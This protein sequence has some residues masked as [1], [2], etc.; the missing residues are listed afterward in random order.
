MGID[1]HGLH[2]LQRVSRLRPFGATMTIARQELHMP[3]LVLAA[4]VAGGAR[5][6]TD[7]YCEPLLIDCFG[8]SRVDSIDNSAFERA[9]FIHDFNRPIAP[10]L[11]GR[12]DTVFDGGS[13]EHIFNLPQALVNCS[14]LCRPG[15]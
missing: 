3:D 2:F 12:Y 11:R 9:T 4:A 5:H 1:T 15:G 6:C 14:L 10:E 8:A 7:H 13:L